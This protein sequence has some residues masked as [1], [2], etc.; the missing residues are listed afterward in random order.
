MMAPDIGWNLTSFDPSNPSFVD[1]LEK[2]MRKKN[3]SYEDEIDDIDDNRG[4][5]TEFCKPTTLF[6]CKSK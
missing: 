3:R 5:E 1:E 2:L 6:L 4:C